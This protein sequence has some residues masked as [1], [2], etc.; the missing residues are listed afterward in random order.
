MDDPSSLP[1]G[2]SANEYSAVIHGDVVSPVLARAL[3]FNDE[4]LENP[5]DPEALVLE[6]EV[7]EPGAAGGAADAAG[8]VP[9]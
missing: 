7:D 4:E 9:I 1:L 2:A 8:V 6:F 5:Q 3:D